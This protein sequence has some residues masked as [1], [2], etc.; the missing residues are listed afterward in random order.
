[1]GDA[2][3]GQQREHPFDHS[4]AVMDQGNIAAAVERFSNPTRC[5]RWT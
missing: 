4:V 3:T 1:M 5:F 2:Q